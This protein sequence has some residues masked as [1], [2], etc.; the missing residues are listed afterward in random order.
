MLLRKSPR[1]SCVCLSLGPSQIFSDKEAQIFSIPILSGVLF[2]F[3]EDSMWPVNHS[4]RLLAGLWTGCPRSV[5]RAGSIPLLAFTAEAV[6]ELSAYQE[7]WAGRKEEWLTF[8]VQ[9]GKLQKCKTERCRSS[10]VHSSAS[11]C[12]E[13]ESSMFPSGATNNLPDITQWSQH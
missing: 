3:W 1:C 9:I 11:R 10:S 12:I 5:V 7:P 8:S 2:H 6:A 13:S 4:C